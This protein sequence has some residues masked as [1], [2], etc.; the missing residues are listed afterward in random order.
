MYC[1]Q[2]LD[3]Y[4]STSLSIMGLL[5]LFRQVREPAKYGKYFEKKKKQSGIL[6]PAKWGWFI[7][8]LPSFLIPIVVILYNQAYDSV[9]SKMLLFMFCGHYFHR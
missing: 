6:V 2:D 8:E 4:M 1:N 7:Q 5:F 3:F 9:G